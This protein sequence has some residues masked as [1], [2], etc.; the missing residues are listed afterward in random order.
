MEVLA[1]LFP[2]RGAL[3]GPRSTVGATE[4]GRVTCR[5]SRKDRSRVRSR[6]GCGRAAGAGL[7]GGS[8]NRSSSRRSTSGGSSD[9]C[10]GSGAGSRTDR[11]TLGHNTRGRRH[12]HKTAQP[13]LHSRNRRSA[14]RPGPSTKR[15]QSSPPR[16]T[17]IAQHATSWE[18]SLREKRETYIRRTQTG[19]PQTLHGPHT[20]RLANAFAKSCSSYGCYRRPGIRS[21]TRWL[22]LPELPTSPSQNMTTVAV[23]R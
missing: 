20:P 15:A 16:T 17:Q 4:R 8:R 22:V 13:R 3:A 19:R 18:S 11:S 23:A 7:R 14:S 12:S 21:L 5:R 1:G 9:E 2:D 6:T 10:G